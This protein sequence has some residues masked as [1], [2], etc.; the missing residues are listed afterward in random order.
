MPPDVL[1][2]CINSLPFQNGSVVTNVDKQGNYEVV[3]PIINEI[4]GSGDVYTRYNNRFDDRTY[5]TT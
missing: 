3:R 5:Y 2:K 4:P 1:T